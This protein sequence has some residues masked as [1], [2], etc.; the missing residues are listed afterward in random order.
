M[1]EWCLTNHNKSGLVRQCL[2]S[3]LTVEE[4]DQKLYQMMAELNITKGLL[5][6]NSVSQ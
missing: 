2:E 1:S 6:G 4:V 3:Q 5:A